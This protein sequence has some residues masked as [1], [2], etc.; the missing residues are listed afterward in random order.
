MRNYEMVLLAL[1]SGEVKSMA[2]LKAELPDLQVHF[3]HKYV[4][5]AKY[6]AGAEIELMKAGAVIKTARAKD[7]ETLRLVN[8]D[9]FK[10]WQPETKTGGSLYRKANPT[11]TKLKT[12][13]PKAPKAP[14]IVK[15]K[16]PKAPKAVAPAVKTKAPKAPKAAAKI[17]M[18]K[19]LQ[20]KV[21][22]AEIVSEA[23][24]PVDLK[25]VVSSDKARGDKIV[26]MI[27]EELKATEPK[28]KR[29]AAALPRG[30]AVA[31]K[32]DPV[33]VERV[34][35]DPTIPLKDPDDL[36]EI[37]EFLQIKREPKLVEE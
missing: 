3:M 25:P 22:P 26:A 7:A 30:P 34:S 32:L 2:D 18:T 37:P 27:R 21:V 9:K 33:K 1:K 6:L 19:D 11:V 24:V 16:A 12:K 29:K 31:A 17:R 36:L 4:A 10:S 28:G 8:A 5:R 15:T 14:K 20:L 13:T 35:D 23:E